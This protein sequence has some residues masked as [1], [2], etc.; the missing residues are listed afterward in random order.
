MALRSHEHYYC[1]KEPFLLKTITPQLPTVMG[2]FAAMLVAFLSLMSGTSPGTCLMKAAAA[3]LVF[4]G[5]GLILRYI[6]L[7]TSE[8]IPGKAGADTRVTPT[9]SVNGSL[10]VIIPGTS[11]ADLLGSVDNDSE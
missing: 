4:A 1:F 3:F 10:D 8:D 9:N 11:V 7:D 5:F 2:S 6:L